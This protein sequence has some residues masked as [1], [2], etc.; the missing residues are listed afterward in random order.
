[1]TGATGLLAGTQGLVPAPAAGDDTNVLYGNGT[2]A[3]VGG[4]YVDPMTT[5]GDMVIRNGAN[6][7]ARLGIG[8]AGHALL[9]TAGIPAWGAVYADPLTVDGDVLI[10]T[11]GV[12]TRLGVGSAG[13]V[14]TVTAG[15][16]AWATP[17][18]G[19]PAGADTQVQY[20]NAGAFGASSGMTWNNTTKALTLTGTGGTASTLAIVLPV[21]AVAGVSVTANSTLTYGMQMT[22]AALPVQN[23]LIVSSV[24][25][26]GNTMA[27]GVLNKIAG[28]HQSIY[29]AAIYA[30]A[31]SSF[32][33]P[34]MTHLTTPSTV[35]NAQYSIMMYANSTGTAGNN[36]GHGLAWLGET[37]T[38]PDT[39]MG[40]LVMYWSVASHGSRTAGAKFVLT[41]GGIQYDAM[42]LTKTDLTFNNELKLTL[43]RS[44]GGNAVLDITN[45]SGNGILL[46]STNGTPFVVVDGTSNTGF[47]WSKSTVQT[48]AD[49]VSSAAHTSEGALFR[50]RTYVAHTSLV[51]FVLIELSKGYHTNTAN[52]VHNVMRIKTNTTVTMPVPT[53]GF[54]LAIDWQMRTSASNTTI[55]V[56][57]IAAVYTDPTA[58]SE[59]A[60]IVFTLIRAGAMTE[61]A[62]I[63][64]TGTLRIG[65]ASSYVAHKPSSGT[66]TYTWPTGYPAAASGYYLTS[67][68]AGV[69]SWA[70]VSGMTNPMTTNGDMIYQAAGVPD[71]LAIGATDGLF[72]V[73]NGGIPE[74]SRSISEAPATMLLTLRNTNAI[75][76]GVLSLGNIADNSQALT[77]IS[78]TVAAS[79]EAAGSGAVVSLAN[80]GSSWTTV[81]DMLTMSKTGT[82]GAAG[83]GV[84]VVT[85]MNDDS[86]FVRY[87]MRHGVIWESAA[88]ASYTSSMIVQLVRAGGSLATVLNING[89]G[90]VTSSN[91][92][93]TTNAAVIV[94]TTT[95]ATTGTAAA[96][97][98]TR[99]LWQISDTG[100]ALSDAAALDIAW[101]DATAASEDAVIEYR[102]AAGGTLAK[103]VTIGSAFV[104]VNSASGEIRVNGTKVLTA[105]QTGWGT[106]TGTI[107]RNSFDTTTVTL[108]EL[109]ERVYGLITDLSTHGA[110]GA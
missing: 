5:I 52:V 23:M 46:N 80:S 30:A 63:I 85:T 26:G 107:D 53:A 93:A 29:Q 58:A 19:S 77:A 81:Y 48:L 3:A 50:L 10:R 79:F 31:H 83:N 64:G 38:T 108:E 110:I 34:L 67:D 11:G 82:S 49:W 22:S 104:D 68:T 88:T 102:V 73:T 86:N 96:A 16:P 51:D 78:A 70:T 41:S 75:S 72:L 6:V 14:L 25:G 54:G 42:T 94:A 101:T 95:L 71:R 39:L 17:S 9:V 56:A 90:M 91:T 21:S 84:A 37:S 62:R 13:Q 27:V 15:I 8:T 4:G 45:S 1:M 109:A 100:G 24:D 74:W 55:S 2:W 65:S 76:Y 47:A 106:P 105:R 44:S 36:F 32:S 69:L 66:T 43:N 28:T 18:A 87:A 7:T 61:A 89:S 98:A 92:T 97:L 20:N 103:V 59:D 99:H 57:N 60:D 35:T 40:S 12:T 33:V